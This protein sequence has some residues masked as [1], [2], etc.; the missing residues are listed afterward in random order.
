MHDILIVSLLLWIYRISHL[1]VC[2]IA[3]QILITNIYRYYEAKIHFHYMSVSSA[4]DNLDSGLSWSFIFY[5]TQDNLMNLW[6]TL[7]YYAKIA[8]WK[9]YIIVKILWMILWFLIIQWQSNRIMINVIMYMNDLDNS[10]CFIYSNYNCY[11]KAYL[12][13][14]N[15]HCQ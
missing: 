13:S 2:A 6:N 5:K 4:F 8:S 11:R 1:T 9:N 3:I 12:R 15:L 10:S 14:S 7:W